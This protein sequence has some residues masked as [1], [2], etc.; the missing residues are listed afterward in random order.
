M[1]FSDIIAL[2]TCGASIV[3]AVVAIL[4]YRK[5]KKE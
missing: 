3:S 1:T 5:D 2:V 4:S